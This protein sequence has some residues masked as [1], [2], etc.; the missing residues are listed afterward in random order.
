MG[1]DDLAQPKERALKRPGAGGQERNQHSLPAC[2][3]QPG[4]PHSTARSGLTSQRPGQS[5]FMS[6]LS[7]VQRVRWLASG[8]SLALL[9]WANPGSSRLAQ[10]GA[11]AAQDGVK[12]TT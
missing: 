1:S 6:E 5:C 9:G 10:Q 2:W 11:R 4:Q 12:G 8:P 7:E 3:N